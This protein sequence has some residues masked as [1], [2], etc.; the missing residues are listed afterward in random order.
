MR[1]PSFSVCARVDV[2]GLRERA[3]RHG[4]SPWLAYH[5][6]ALAAANEIDAL[7]QTL[8]G[9]GVR[10]FA[11]VHASTTVLRDDGSFGIVSGV[12]SVFVQNPEVSQIFSSR[13]TA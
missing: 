3:L 7:R 6:A 9:E 4:A 2:T 10:E 1:H 13:S 8:D 11:Q 12:M 5:H